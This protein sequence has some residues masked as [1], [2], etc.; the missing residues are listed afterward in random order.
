MTKNINYPHL[1]TIV[2]PSTAVPYHAR[3]P[4]N[5]SVLAKSDILASEMKNLDSQ[6]NV[7]SHLCLHTVPEWDTSCS[8]VRHKAL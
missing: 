8:E 1:T 3:F 5:N 4:I 7:K 6:W 2:V